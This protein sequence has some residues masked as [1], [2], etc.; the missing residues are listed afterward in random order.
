MMD[1]A[2]VW[3][4]LSW[5]MS[6]SHYATTSR[7]RMVVRLQIIC[8]RTW[9]PSDYIE[10]TLI[11]VAA[12]TPHVRVRANS[13]M[14]G[15]GRDP[16]SK[17]ARPKVKTPVFCPSGAFFVKMSFPA[18]VGHP[19]N[20]PFRAVGKFEI[21]QFLLKFENFSIFRISVQN[22]DSSACV[23]INARGVRIIRILVPLYCVS[24][25]IQRICV[26]S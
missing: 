8:C 11:V 17:I 24:P 25:R 15:V 7:K 14:G 5:E 10:S 13:D 12:H 3:Q 23:R 1:P 26:E 9:L 2:V 19:P 20:W 18:W 22:S 16:S 21:F 6:G 4:L